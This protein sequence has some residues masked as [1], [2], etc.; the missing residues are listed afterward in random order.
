MT[1][2]DWMKVV[3]DVL[4]ILGGTYTIY[5]MYRARVEQKAD[6]RRTNELVKEGLLPPSMKNKRITSNEY[7][8]YG[9]NQLTKVID[10]SMK[11]LQ[12]VLEQRRT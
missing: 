3:I 2:P 9:L 6:F 4:A 10:E 8:L 7:L 1:E 11:H 5:R 12:N